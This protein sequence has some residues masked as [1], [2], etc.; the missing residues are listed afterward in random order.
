MACPGKNQAG[1]L[2][3]N[4]DSIL[5]VDASL[6]RPV[7]AAPIQTKMANVLEIMP[8]KA[9]VDAFKFEGSYDYL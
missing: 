7:L 2:E 8:L 4:Q 9:I 5:C 6:S 3:S 1:S